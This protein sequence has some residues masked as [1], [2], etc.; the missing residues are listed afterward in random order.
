MK[1][2]RKNL[3]GFIFFIFLTA[4]AIFWIFPL[5]GTIPVLMYHYLDDQQSAEK[6][7][8]NPKSFESQMNFLKMFGYRVISMDEYDEIQMGRRQP[9][10]REVVITFDDGHESFFTYAYPVLKKYHFPVIMFMISGKLKSEE[11]LSEAQVKQMFQEDPLFMIGAHTQTHPHLPEISLEEAKKEILGSKQD[12]EQ[13][14]GRPIFYFAYPHGEFNSELL[15]LVQ[16]AGYRRAFT[17]SFKKLKN[18]EENQYAMTRLKITRSSDNPIA[19]WFKLSG[20][21]TAFK[22]YRH[23]VKDKA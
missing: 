20:L 9:K 4:A 16:E 15:K 12:L 8:I 5:K 19:F 22:Y 2:A 18:L 1:T 11:Y 7:L 3:S 14:F 21:Y 23:R 10:G 17:T 6:N 13:I